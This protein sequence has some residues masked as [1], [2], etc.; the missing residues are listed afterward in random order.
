MAT[1]KGDSSDT[2]ALPAAIHDCTVH[3]HCME[4]RRWGS[5]SV[6]S[7]C[8]CLIRFLLRAGAWHDPK[9][10]INIFLFS[11]T[12]QHTNIRYRSC[13]ARA[14]YVGFDYS[15]NGHG[16]RR[17]KSTKGPQKECVATSS[18]SILYMISPRAATH[19]KKWRR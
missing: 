4:S 5:D 6:H 3:M 2:N 19:G 15:T 17:V 12:D 9:D 1:R 8:E 10:D 11:L 18:A 16:A 14:W 7:L 13:R